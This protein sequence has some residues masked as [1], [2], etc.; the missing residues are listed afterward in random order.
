MSNVTLHPETEKEVSKLELRELVDRGLKLYREVSLLEKKKN[1]L[2][3]IKA[4]IREEAKGREIEF[5]GSNGAVARVEQKPDTVCRVVEETAVP[6][7][8]K[9]SG[10]SLLDLFTIH[11]SKGKEKSFELNALKNLPK[12]AAQSL[13]DLLKVEATAWVRFS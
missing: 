13:I 9:L 6:R 10:P 5:K 1:E 3:Q 4:V 8:V 11:P 12:K 7:A 2:E